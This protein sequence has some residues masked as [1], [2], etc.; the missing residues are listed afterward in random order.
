MTAALGSILGWV[1]CAP[2]FVQEN[3]RLARKFLE[4]HPDAARVILPSAERRRRLHSATSSRAMNASPIVRL[5]ICARGS[6][7]CG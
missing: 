1:A 2:A 7:M 4:E 3:E 6:L 5:S